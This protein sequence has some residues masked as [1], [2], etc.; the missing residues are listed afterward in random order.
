MLSS[1]HDICRKWEQKR[2]MQILEPRL[3]YPYRD[4]VRKRRRIRKC[5]PLSSD[6]VAQLVMDVKGMSWIMYKISSPYRLLL[7]RNIA[8]AYST[9]Q[10]Q[11]VSNAGVCKARKSTQSPRPYHDPSALQQLWVKCQGHSRRDVRLSKRALSAAAKPGRQFQFGD[12]IAANVLANK[13]IALMY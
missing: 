10:P 2:L 6:S 12:L 11:A 7:T 4:C 8:K 5:R 1:S 9:P 13:A 3:H